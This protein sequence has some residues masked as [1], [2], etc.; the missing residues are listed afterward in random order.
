MNNQVTFG[1]ASKQSRAIYIEADT[2]DSSILY[3]SSYS[4][5]APLHCLR[6]VYKMEKI[7]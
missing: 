5:K 2:R 6:W 1:I 3:S 7:V 4:T